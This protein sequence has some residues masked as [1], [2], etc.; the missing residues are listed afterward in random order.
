VPSFLLLFCIYLILFH[1]NL[2]FHQDSVPGFIG[3]CVCARACV[4]VCGHTYTSIH[5]HTHTNIH[6]DA[7]SY[8]F[9]SSLMA[10]THTHTHRERHADTCSYR[11]IS[12]L[13]ASAPFLEARAC[14]LLSIIA[15]QSLY[16]LVCMCV[17]TY[18][19]VY[20]YIQIRRYVY[21]SWPTRASQQDLP[22]CVCVFVCM[23]V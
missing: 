13:M 4:C 23:H 7:C 19:Y 16:C 8:R 5:T 6:T 22:V 15:S 10:H 20:T 18:I 3:V 2:I 14:I 9:T 21:S 11:F 17:C 1:I 12:S